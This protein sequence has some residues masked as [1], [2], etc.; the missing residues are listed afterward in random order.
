MPSSWSCIPGDRS[1]GIRSCSCGTSSGILPLTGLTHPSPTRTQDAVCFL[2]IPCLR[3]DTAIEWIHFGGHSRNDSGRLD[4][5]TSKAVPV[6][7]M[8]FW[9]L[10][11]LFCDGSSSTRLTIPLRLLTSF[12]HSSRRQSDA[13]GVIV[14]VKSSVPRESSLRFHPHPARGAPLDSHGFQHVEKAIQS[15]RTTPA[16]WFSMIGWPR[17]NGD[18]C[19]VGTGLFNLRTVG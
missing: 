18:P 8:I 7:E 16:R 15:L 10:T 6:L 1:A 17:R 3:N 9:P 5:P 13:E 4:R 12:V 19:R 2:L 14:G 11:A